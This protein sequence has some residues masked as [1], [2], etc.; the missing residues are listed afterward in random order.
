MAKK[1]KE[2]KKVFRFVFQAHVDIPAKD[3]DEAQ[4]KFDEADL[5]KEMEYRNTQDVFE[6]EFR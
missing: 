6:V 3:E 2:K 4:L 1:T 5:G